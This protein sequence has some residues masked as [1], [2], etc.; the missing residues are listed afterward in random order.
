MSKGRIVLQY[1]NWITKM[2][3]QTVCIDY[4]RV[5]TGLFTMLCKGEEKM[6]INT[7]LIILLYN[8]VHS[9]Y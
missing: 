8:S 4:V 3:E 5:S 7:L 6:R 2:A 9:F 1:N